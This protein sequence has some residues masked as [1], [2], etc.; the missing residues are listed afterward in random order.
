MLRDHQ[1][2]WQAQW[3]ALKSTPMMPALWG[4]LV[5]AGDTGNS[6]SFVTRPRGQVQAPSSALGPQRG[7][8]SCFSPSGFPRQVPGAHPPGSPPEPNARQT[9][10]MVSLML[11]SSLDL[12]W[13]HKKLGW[14]EILQNVFSVLFW[15]IVYDP[16]R[17]WNS[18]W[19]PGGRKRLSSH[20]RSRCPLSGGPG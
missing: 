14:G 7:W 12:G 16:C 3:T 1:F 8:P 17:K 10:Q 11:P 5:A 18:W 15:R 9:C 6:A 4:N 19:L 13:E 20:T 2:S